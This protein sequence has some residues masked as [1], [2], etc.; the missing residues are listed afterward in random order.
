MLATLV[1][2]PANPAHPVRQHLP[3]SAAKSR[4]NTSL[5]SVVDPHHFVTDPDSIDHPDADPESDFYLM[6][7]RMRIRIRSLFDADP[8]P[9]FHPDADPDLDPGFQIKAQTLKKKLK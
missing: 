3:M 4:G 5:C 1:E 2:G 8:D 6:Q 9:T 7:R